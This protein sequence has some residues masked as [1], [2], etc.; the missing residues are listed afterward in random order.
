MDR[1]IETVAGDPMS[2]SSELT[3]FGKSNGE[4]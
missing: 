2:K 1:H 4:N 3:Q